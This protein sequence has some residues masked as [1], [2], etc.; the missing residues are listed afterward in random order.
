MLS[1]PAVRRVKGATLQRSR[2]ERAYMTVM[3]FGDGSQGALGQSHLAGSV[4]SDAYEPAPVQALP[5]NI[6]RVSAGHYHS[7]ALSADGGLWS[8][9]RN[10]EGQLGRGTSLS[11]EECYNPQV[12][13]GLEGVNVKD[14]AGSGVISMV[15]D[16]HG[17]LWAWGKSKRG[18]LG[19]GEGII[20]APSPQRVQALFGQQIVQVSLGWGHALACTAEGNLYSWGY[21]ADGRLGYLPKGIDSH[22]MQN[23]SIDQLIGNQ[24]EL[25]EEDLRKEFDLVYQWEPRLVPLDDLKAVGVSCGFDHSLVICENGSLLSFGN[26]SYGQLGRASGTIDLA[27]EW[28]VPLEGHVACI[29]SGLGHSLAVFR[30]CRQDEDEKMDPMYSN[31][32]YSWGWNSAFQLGR[33]EFN[34]RPMQVQGLEERHVLTVDGGRVHSLAVDCEGELWTW[35]SGKNGRLGLGSFGDEQEPCLVESI[36]ELKV[37]QAVCGMD[38]TIILLSDR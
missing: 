23:V 5:S 2:F 25:M 11:R 14:I 33:T 19:L 32:V 30:G 4:A 15:I 9:G 35:G 37:Q 34:K 22:G 21:P 36:Q 18:Q 17:S 6:I 8:W 10:N 20:E 27:K 29:G 38:H 26:N 31:S 12:V 3:S 16:A 28:R 7:L 13:K 24:H 1:L